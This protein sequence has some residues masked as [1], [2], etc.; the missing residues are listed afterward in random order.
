M[1]GVM[2]IGAWAPEEV[3]SS[4]SESSNM[5]SSDAPGLDPTA[6]GGVGPSSA[7]ST[8]LS[9]VWFGSSVVGASGRLDASAIGDDPGDS[10]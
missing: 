7:G 4:S 10:A 9:W 5:S 8:S 1:S 3:N 2:Y 6:A